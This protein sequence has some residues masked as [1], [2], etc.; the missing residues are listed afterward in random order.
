MKELKKYRVDIAG[1]QNKRYEYDFEVGNAFFEHFEKSLV[2]KANLKVEA[3][4]EK[5]ET[6]I[7]IDFRIRGFVNLVCDRSL[8]EFDHPTEVQERFIFKFGEGDIERDDNLVFI[9]TNAQSIDL[10]E[11]IYEVVSLSIP[12]KKIH[13][14]YREGD[15]DS[16]Q[17]KFIY[18]SSTEND[19]DTEEPDP[20]WS[21]LNDL[22]K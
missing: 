21:I 20:R 12:M 2:K 17:N 1:L 6:M 16:E 5:S 8:E 13:P 3:I 15:E 9:P 4:L 7:L 10:S 18:T 22:K 19:K 14:L 11:Y